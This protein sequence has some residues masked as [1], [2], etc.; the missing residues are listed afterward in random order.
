[1]VFSLFRDKIGE[2]IKISDCIVE[3]AQVKR[4]WEKG[5]AVS[6]SGSLSR[7]DERVF[8]AEVR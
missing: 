5:N 4:I 8:G 2:K 3:A 6:D 7:N 1:M